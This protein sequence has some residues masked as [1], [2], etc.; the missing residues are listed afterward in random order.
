MDWNALWDKVKIFFSQTWDFIYPFIKQFMSEE[1]TMILMMA[2]N[3][4]AEIQSTMGDADGEAKRSEAL[5]RL[6]AALMA[7][8]FKIALSVLNSAIEMA[9]AKL[10]ATPEV[11]EEAKML[12]EAMESP[13]IQ[14][15]QP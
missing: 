6:E 12:Q 8:G 5:A 2:L 4:C 15:V 3:V 9:V 14:Q 7:Q 10:K 13:P 1:G 11:V